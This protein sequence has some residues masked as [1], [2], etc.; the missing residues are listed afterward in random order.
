MDETGIEDA[1]SPPPNPLIDDYLLIAR[2]ACVLNKKPAHSNISN[3]LGTSVKWI[4]PHHANLHVDGLAKFAELGV[5]QR[6]VDIIT[7]RA[8][9]NIGMDKMCSHGLSIMYL[10]FLVL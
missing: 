3:F 1:D 2:S 8:T 9:P 5:S 10:A 7:S 6:V 4:N